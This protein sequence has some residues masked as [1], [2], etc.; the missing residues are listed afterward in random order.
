MFAYTGLAPDQV[1]RLVEEFHIFL[2][3]SGR[4]SLA[5]INTVN[6]KKV[7][8]AFHEVSKGKKIGGWA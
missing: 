4:I 3:D 8:E 5:G 2:L 6:V 7:A 1:R